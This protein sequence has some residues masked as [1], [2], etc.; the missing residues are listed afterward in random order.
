ME[1]DISTR[2]TQR[3]FAFQRIGPL[4]ILG[5]VG[6]LVLY[7][8]N[9]INSIQNVE[10][11][12]LFF[13]PMFCIPMII[14]GAVVTIAGYSKAMPRY[15][16]NRPNPADFNR[17]DFFRAPSPS[18]YQNAPEDR[19]SRINPSSP[20]KVKCRACGGLSNPGTTYCSHC[21]QKLR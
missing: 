4:L 17:K 2:D 21:G 12:V 6:L 8:F 7:I 14:I 3:R 13:L 20:K 15:T 9:F 5:G 1:K 18:A 19:T 16:M 11:P 10:F